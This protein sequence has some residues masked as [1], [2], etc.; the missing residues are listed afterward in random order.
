[1]I[2]KGSLQDVLQTGKAW[3]HYYESHKEKLR[4]IEVETRVKMLSCGLSVRG[5]AQYA[6]E[7]LGCGHTKV[8]SFTCVRRV[9]TLL[10]VRKRRWLGYSVSSQSYRICSGSTLLS[11]YRKPSGAS[12]S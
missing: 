2:H 1:M 9:I 6:C 11:R 3:W 4:P 10:A 12:F 8:V 5:Y 7:T